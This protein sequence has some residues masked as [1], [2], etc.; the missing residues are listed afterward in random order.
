MSQNILFLRA[1]RGRAIGPALGVYFVYGVRVVPLSA[2]AVVDSPG[3]VFQW[4]GVRVFSVGGGQ[5]FFAAGPF[6]GVPWWVLVWS[7]PVPTFWLSFMPPGVG[8]GQISV[9]RFVGRCWLLIAAAFMPRG[10]AIQYKY[11]GSTYTLALTAL[12]RGSFCRNFC[13]RTLL[14]L[15]CDPARLE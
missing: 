8:L 9:S 11:L 15:R 7:Q 4:L 2:R 1:R 12:P 3:L 14:T 6:L 5:R 13:H 10:F